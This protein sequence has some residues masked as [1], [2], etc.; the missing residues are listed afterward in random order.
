MVK[1][2][3]LVQ[4]ETENERLVNM[5]QYA[6]ELGLLNVD[7]VLLEQLLAGKK[8]ENQYILD[9]ATHSHGDQPLISLLREIYENIDLNTATGEG[10][11]KLG[12]LV[13]VIRY[14]AQTPQVRIEISFELNNE[15]DITIPAGTPVILGGMIPEVYGNYVTAET[16]TINAGTTMTSVLAVGTEYGV[17]TSLPPNTV[18]GLDGFSF[19][20]C[21]NP[22]EGT[23]GRNI[24]ED[25]EYRE[26]IQQNARIN[27]RGTRECIEDYLDHFN[28]LDGYCLIPCYEGVGTLKVVCDTLEENLPNIS[29]GLSDNCMIETDRDPVC[30]LPQ[31]H[32]VEGVSFTVTRNPANITLTNDEL[33]QLVIAQTNTF[34]HGGITRDGL[35]REGLHIG[36]SLYPSKLLTYLMNSFTEILNIESNLEEIITVEPTE[37]I[38]LNSVNVVFE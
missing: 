17:Q 28:G 2:W 20:T 32:V 29:E 14:P 19:S 7:E 25:D 16:V 3:L 4:F 12:K 24:E 21:T 15:F 31:S 38:T 33:S 8:T 26:R 27:T 23:C 9:F 35:K 34:V 37:K 22:E 10:L 13:N 5:V 30:V 36:E 18:R 1:R 6:G 11:D